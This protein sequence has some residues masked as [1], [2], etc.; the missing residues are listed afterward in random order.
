MAKSKKSSGISVE[1]FTHK[2]DMLEVKVDQIERKV[3]NK[4]D[5]IV[6]VQILEHRRELEEIYRIIQ[7]ID[8]HIES[9]EA[10]LRLFEERKQQISE[11]QE[12]L[13]LS[14]KNRKEIKGSK[15]MSPL[16]S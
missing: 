10:Q 1:T 11:H 2:L 9:I 3:A 15:S 16:F 13:P 14:R 12:T 8:V 5:E 7:D 6:T 4:A